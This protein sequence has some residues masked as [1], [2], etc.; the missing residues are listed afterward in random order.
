MWTVVIIVLVVGVGY[1]LSLL[2][3]P[4][5]RCSRCRGKPRKQGAIFSYS[6]RV[7]PRCQGTGQERR[8]G[9]RLFRMDK[10]E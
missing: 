9:R 8:L 2:L 1:Y 6:H 7:C 5:A 4:W 10:D 3:H